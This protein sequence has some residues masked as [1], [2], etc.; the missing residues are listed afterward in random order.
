MIL[1]SFS[2]VSKKTPGRRLLTLLGGLLRSLWRASTVVKSVYNS[3]SEGTHLTYGLCSS[4]LS[5]SLPLCNA[6]F[7]MSKS[8]ISS[9][10]CRSGCKYGRIYT[11]ISCGCYE[12]LD[13]ALGCP[14]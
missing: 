10:C 1:F 12:I 5:S 6:G 2:Q 9:L 8:H 14:V 7:M 11:I 4:P 3:F 13:P